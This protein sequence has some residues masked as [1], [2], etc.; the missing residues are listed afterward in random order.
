ME[1]PFCIHDLCARVK[2]AATS[3]NA[4]REEL[5]DQWHR[6]PY[7]I[8]ITEIRYAGGRYYTL[9]KKGYNDLTANT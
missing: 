9:Q 5:G 6:T 3:G 2:L 1:E 7:I 8:V 4:A